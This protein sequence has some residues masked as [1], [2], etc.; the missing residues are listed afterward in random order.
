MAKIEFL[1]LHKHKKQRT[2]R[3]V[4]SNFKPKLNYILILGTFGYMQSN[5]LE[6]ARRIIVRELSKIGKVVIKI[7]PKIPV[8]KK[9]TG[10]R[11]GKGKGKLKDLTFFGKPGHVAIQIHNILS[12]VAGKSFRVARK[13]L[14]FK[15]IISK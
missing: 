13:K 2:I 4:N 7:Q 3:K 12:D 1:K 15:V 10:S 6:A 8:L 11:M 9:A 14:P 5:Q